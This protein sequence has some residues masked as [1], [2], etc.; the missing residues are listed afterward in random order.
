MNMVLVMTW[1]P[2]VDKHLRSIEEEM[3]VTAK[4]ISILLQKSPGDQM[5]Q[6]QLKEMRAKETMLVSAKK[7]CESVIGC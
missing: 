6:G 2:S 1:K 4:C 7:A 3:K 5:A